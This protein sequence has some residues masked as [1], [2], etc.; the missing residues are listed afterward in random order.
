MIDIVEYFV[1]YLYTMSKGTFQKSYLST[2]R[3]MKS[4]PLQ[5]LVDNLL[6]DLS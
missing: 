3:G 5:S 4:T 6:T 1:V 2:G